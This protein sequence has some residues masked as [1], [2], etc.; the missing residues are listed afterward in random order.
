MELTLYLYS[1]MCW[2]GCCIFN[3]EMFLT[4][5]SRFK[6][7]TA[8]FHHRSLGIVNYLSYCDKTFDSYCYKKQLSNSV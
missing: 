8:P 1:E 4:L 3:T 5:I 2:N 6:D 7:L